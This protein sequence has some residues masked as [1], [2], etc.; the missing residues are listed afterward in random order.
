MYT[1]FFKP[2]LFQSSVYIVGY[3]YNNVICSLFSVVAVH[4]CFTIRNP[5]YIKIIQF[6]SCITVSAISKVLTA[7][8]Q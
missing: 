5:L 1:T 4:F 6:S 2:V 7:G 3:S 8:K